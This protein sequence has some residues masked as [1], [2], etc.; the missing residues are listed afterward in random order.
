M[1]LAL[2]KGVGQQEDAGATVD[3]EQVVRHIGGR[4]AA[5]GRACRLRQRP[6]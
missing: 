2:G 3:D 5:A 4:Q 1:H 6:Q